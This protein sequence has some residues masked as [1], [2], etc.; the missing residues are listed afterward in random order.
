MDK[1]HEIQQK[2]NMAD[3]RSRQDAAES[4]FLFIEQ[5][6]QKFTTTH[7]KMSDVADLLCK[8]ITD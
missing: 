5:N 3:W 6:S 8:L 4:L 2:F 1:V 7:S